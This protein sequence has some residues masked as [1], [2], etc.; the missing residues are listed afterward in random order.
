MTTTPVKALL[1]VLPSGAWGMCKTDDAV[2]DPHD[3]PGVGTLCGEPG[4]QQGTKLKHFNG[5]PKKRPVV[6]WHWNMLAE[7][8]GYAV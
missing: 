7:E 4:D 5:F 2:D 8:Q 3:Q 1:P 6:G